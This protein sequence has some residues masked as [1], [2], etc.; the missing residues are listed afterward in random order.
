MPVKAAA[1][2]ATVGLA[3]GSAIGA[4]LAE[5][6]LAAQVRLAARGPAG[7]V[8]EAAAPV[9]HRAWALSEAAG[10]GAGVVAAVNR[11]GDNER[12]TIDTNVVQAPRCLLGNV[13]TALRQ[14]FSAGA[15]G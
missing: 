2:L 6:D 13:C 8:P 14:N 5:A 12:D 4:S 3:T 1:T 10:E 11:D 7:R 9:E 15:C